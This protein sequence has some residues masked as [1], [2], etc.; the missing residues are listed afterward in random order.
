[1]ERPSEGKYPQ[2]L[3]YRV[4]SERINLKQLGH[5]YLMVFLDAMIYGLSFEDWLPESLLRARWFGL[6]KV[7]KA[8]R[9][10]YWFAATCRICTSFS[11]PV[12]WFQLFFARDASGATL[13]W[14][15]RLVACSARSSR[16]ALNRRNAPDV[17]A[18]RTAIR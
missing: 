6:T 15:L 16:L 9:A 3:D 18:V 10:S 1:M 17:N 12:S 2:V 13:R 11:H 5:V 14:L 7:G 4:L 8:R